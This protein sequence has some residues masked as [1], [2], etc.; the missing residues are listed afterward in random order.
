MLLPLVGSVTPLAIA[1]SVFNLS[2]LP[3]LELWI[4]AR[5]LT[6][7][8]DGDG[9]TT[10]SDLSG[11]GRDF[12]Q[13][14][15]SKKWQYKTGI[16]NSLPVARADG[17][18]DFM[19]AGDT[20]GFERTDDWTIYAVANFTTGQEGTLLGKMDPATAFRG[21]AV[22]SS[23]GNGNKPYAFLVN[24]HPSNYVLETY[25][26]TSFFGAF[27]VL[28][29]IYTGNSD[30]SGLS[31]YVDNVL[32][33]ETTVANTLTATLANAAVLALGARNGTAQFFAGDLAEAAVA[34]AAHGATDRTRANQYLANLY[35]ITLP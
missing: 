30:V 21:W 16:V 28:T 29:W 19:S 10:L 17:V 32:R 33:S 25:D 34:S 13:A 24:T 2:K 31:M 23:N 5:A 18:D 11:H 20:L 14:T 12:S 3:D 35:G 1:S 8:N 22:G 4:A 26:N 9:I 27:H 6:G 7:L 15:A